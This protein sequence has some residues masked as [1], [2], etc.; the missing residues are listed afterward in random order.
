M[1]ESRGGVGLREGGDGV[2]DVAEAEPLANE[3]R[4][5]GGG[6][7]DWR[8]STK[9]G[10]RAEEEK[11]FLRKYPSIFTNNTL[12]WIATNNLDSNIYI[13]PPSVYQ[14]DPSIGSR[15]K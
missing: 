13:K 3:A 8:E 5:G 11:L 6:G 15:S 10:R 4:H 2:A 7:S 9:S 12:I 1:G 14:M